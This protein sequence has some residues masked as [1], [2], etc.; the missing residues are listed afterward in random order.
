M[1]EDYKS[2]FEV[3]ANRVYGLLENHK[4]SFYLGGLE[5]DIW[6]PV[7]IFHPKNL[8]DAYSQAKTQEE[9]IL[10]TRSFRPMRN[11]NQFHIPSNGV[12]AEIWSN[13]GNFLAQKWHY[14]DNQNLS[15]LLLWR[16]DIIRVEKGIFMWC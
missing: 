10:T 1:L 8:T 12:A 3:L 16:V 7:R 9:L 2:Q 5:D 4:L 14:K 11:A 13:K 15:I 6:L